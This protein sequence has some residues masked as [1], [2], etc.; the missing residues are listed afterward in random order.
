M[1]KSTMSTKNKVKLTKDELQMIQ[2]AVNKKKYNLVYDNTVLQFSLN[3][4]NEYLDTTPTVAFNELQMSFHKQVEYA[5]WVLE[6]LNCD[7]DK[8]Y[9][10]EQLKD[11]SQLDWNEFCTHVNK[12]EKW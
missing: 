9:S 7:K 3:E 12:M 4:I 5:K 2:D 10:I 1:T 6:K 11:L 8:V